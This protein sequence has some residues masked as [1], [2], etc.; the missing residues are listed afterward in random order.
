MQQRVGDQ[1]AVHA[2]AQEIGL[3]LQQGQRIARGMRMPVGQE[4]TDLV[5]EPVIE[6]A[7]T[8]DYGCVG[9]SWLIP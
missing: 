3:V 8:G 6:G 4:E 2:L 5:P 7:P 9:V 1:Q